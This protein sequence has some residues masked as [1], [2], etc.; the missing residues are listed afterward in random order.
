MSAFSLAKQAAAA[1]SKEKPRSSIT[2][3]VDILTSSTYDDEVYDGIP[4]L[5]DSIDLQASGRS[6]AE[7][8]R[9]IRK[10]IKHGSTHQQYR[11]LVILNALVEN[12]SRK[13]QSTFADGQLTDALKNLATDSSTDP[14]VKKKVL[15]VLASWS[16]QFKD[17]RSAAGIASLY[18]QVKPAEPPRRSEVDREAMAEREREAEQKRR[19]KDDAKRKAKEERFKIEEEARRQKAASKIASNARKQFDFER[20]KPQVLT[21]IANASSAANNLVNAITLVNTENDSLLT[22]E[23]VQECLVKAKQ[24]RKLIVRYIQASNHFLVEDEEI[25]GTLIET[26]ERIIAALQSYDK[27]SKPNVSEKDIEEVQRGLEAA[28]IAGSEVQRLQEKQHAAVQRAVRHRSRAEDDV[29]ES[30]IHPDLQDLSFGALGPEQRNLQPPIRPTTHPSN[31]DQVYRRGSLSDFSDYES[32]DGETYQLAGQPSGLHVR[33]AY[34]NVSDNS[35]D[36]DGD[37]RGH[38]TSDE[39]P[40]TDPFA[41]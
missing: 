11:A 28:H 38:I 10:K 34:V 26:N 9:A 12:S 6:T 14:K 31:E 32:S 24:A 39:D 16:R 27:L 21:S 35:G 2:E 8:S 33:K 7:A 19:E 23:R 17:D 37:V 36:D 41:D 22:N 25:I 18:R 4:E 30:P 5:I 3:W 29:S 40:F 20:E 15:A 1:F 13:F